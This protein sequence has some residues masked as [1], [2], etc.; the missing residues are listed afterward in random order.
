ETRGLADGV[1]DGREAL[2][3]L[4]RHLDDDVLVARRDRGLTQTE[5][6]DATQDD[7]ARLADRALA[8][9]RADRGPN[10]EQQ[11]ATIFGARERHLAAELFEEALVQLRRI[12]ALFDGHA[13]LVDRL[14]RRFD[15]DLVAQFLEGFVRGQ[16]VA[17]VQPVNPGGFGAHVLVVVIALVFDGF[18]DVHRIDEAQAAAKIQAFD[19]AK[20]DVLFDVRRALDRAGPVGKRGP[21]HQEGERTRASRQRA[22]HTPTEVHH[23]DRGERDP[24]AQD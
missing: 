12:G 23:L 13:N 8:D 16:V 21:K 19:Q 7:V 24:Q 20:R 14:T 4:T 6:V 18:V 17:G 10:L 2:F 9:L 22:T 1:A 5:L 11:R 3:V 15:L